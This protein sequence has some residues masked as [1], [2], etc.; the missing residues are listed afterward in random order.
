[1]IFTH[2]LKGRTCEETSRLKIGLCQE[3]G[4]SLTQSPPISVA[5]CVSLIV[6]AV[7]YAV[8]ICILFSNW[9]YKCHGL[10]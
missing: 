2:F 1:M 6:R 8:L 4:A 5:F 7:I 3:D 9:L 10:S